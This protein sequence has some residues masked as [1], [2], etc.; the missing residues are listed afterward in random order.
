M[1]K[2]EKRRGGRLRGVG[3]GRTVLQ[4]ENRLLGPFGGG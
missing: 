4:A 3:G 1:L 2:A